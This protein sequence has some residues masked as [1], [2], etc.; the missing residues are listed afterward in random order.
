[1]SNQEMSQLQKDTGLVSGFWDF[2]IKQK[3]NFNIEKAKKACTR[4]QL[5][6]YTR[7]QFWNYFDVQKEFDKYKANNEKEKE[8]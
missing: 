1:M 8:L 7:N 6:T 2:L 3:E 4:I 5:R